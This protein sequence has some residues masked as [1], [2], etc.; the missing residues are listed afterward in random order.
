MET[1]DQFLQRRYPELGQVD[2]VNIL[3][4][5][6]R[7]QSFEEFKAQDPYGIDLESYIRVLEYQGKKYIL[8]MSDY[9][10]NLA[11]YIASYECSLSEIFYGNRDGLP[12][13]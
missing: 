3:S 10:R 12:L 1:T 13:N 5:I 2:V 9:Q 8:N 6:N 7:V 11:S 4:L